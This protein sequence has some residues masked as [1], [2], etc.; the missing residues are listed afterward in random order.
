MSKILF[1]NELIKI[2]SMFTQITGVPVKDC[3]FDETKMTFIIPSGNIRQALGQNNFNLRKLEDRFK[4]KIRMVEFQP[5]MIKF[6]KNMI[7]PFKVDD[8][9]L[10]DD[11]TV[12]LKSEDQKTK[13]LIIGKNARNLRALETNV[14][15]YFDD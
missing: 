1:D 9:I 14:K 5:D 10:L 3:F 2:M 7:L 4:K 8:I 12:I 6:I 11:K 13:G 15:R